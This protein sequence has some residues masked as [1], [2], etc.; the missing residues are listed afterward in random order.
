MVVL[1]HLSETQ[2]RAYIL[3]DNKLAMNAGWDEKMLARERRELEKDGMDLA[4]TGFS[5]EEPGAL[6]EEHSK[7]STSAGTPTDETQR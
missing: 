7:P 4:V 2:R 1:D 5:D 6:L 3:P